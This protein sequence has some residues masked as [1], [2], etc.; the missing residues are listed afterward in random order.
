MET[1]AEE[2]DLLGA[3]LDQRNLPILSNFHGLY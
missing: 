2:L 1:L 3:G